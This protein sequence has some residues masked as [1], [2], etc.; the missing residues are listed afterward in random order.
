[1]RS[2]N[3]IT[4][5]SS[6]A[7]PVELP[8]N[9]LVDYHALGTLPNVWHAQIWGDHLISHIELKKTLAL[10][11]TKI[12]FER[13]VSWITGF[14]SW[15]TVFFWDRR[16]QAT[17]PIASPGDWW[18]GWSLGKLHWRRPVPAVVSCEKFP[19]S[20]EKR[21][22]SSQFAISSGENMLETGFQ[23]GIQGYRMF[24]QIHMTNLRCI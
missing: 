22:E 1:M 17:S 6:W 15:K 8:E 12:F 3:H 9:L 5:T 21:G 11:W 19:G 20:P 18:R 7:I 13:W 23:H 24:K 16:N 2:H 10:D 14:P 4:I